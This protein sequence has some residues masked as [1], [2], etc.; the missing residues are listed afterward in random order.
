MPVYPLRRVGL[1]VD[2]N[3]H[4]LSNS[5]SQQRTG[6]PSV[7]SQRRGEVARRQFNAC[8]ADPQDVGWI[9]LRYYSGCSVRERL[10]AGQDRSSAR[11]LE[12]R[13]PPE[14]HVI[15]S[16]GE[17]KGAWMRYTSTRRPEG[18]RG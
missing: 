3:P 1:V 15:A 12:K 9:S 4:L 14:C 7:V 16:L 5:C 8:L 17:R 6:K 10:E 18:G 2:V 13:S 11:Q